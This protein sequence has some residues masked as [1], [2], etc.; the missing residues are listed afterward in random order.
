MRLL[1]RMTR[2]AGRW[3]DASY[4]KEAVIT[5]EQGKSPVLLIDSKPVPPDTANRVHYEVLKAKERELAMLNR[6]DY[7][8]VLN[9]VTSK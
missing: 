3:V 4:T 9:G 8:F 2:L 5:A 7:R 1:A 6:C